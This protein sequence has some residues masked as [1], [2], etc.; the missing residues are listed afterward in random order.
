MG[1]GL[2]YVMLNVRSLWPNINELKTNFVDYD[3]IGLSETW[4]NCNVT[5]TMIDFPGFEIIRQDQ[6]STKR[7]GGLLCE[8]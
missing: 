5:D 1:K 8:T 3:I 2:R 7:G 6:N 4:L